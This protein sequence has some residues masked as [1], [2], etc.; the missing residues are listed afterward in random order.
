MKMTIDDSATTF[1]LTGPDFSWFAFGFDTTVMQG[2]SFIV[3]GLDASRTAVEQ[4]LV[5]AGNPGAPQ[6]EQNITI[7]STTHDALNNLTTI[8]IERPNQ[9][10]D[11]EDPDFST[12]MTQLDVIWAFRASASPASPSP[13]LNF[14][15]ANGRGVASISFSPVPEPGTA[16]LTFGL[17]LATLCADDVRLAR[18]MAR[19]RTT[20]FIHFGTTRRTIGRRE[21]A[22]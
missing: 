1:E 10:G 3:E 5:A 7:L 9:T 15:G 19:E 21:R 6:D 13:T 22:L 11:P 12:S 8:V 20:A 17:G 2:Y 4:N 16:S 14:H 18:I